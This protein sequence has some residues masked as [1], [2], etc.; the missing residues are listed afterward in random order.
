MR[1]RESTMAIL[2]T[3]KIQGKKVAAE[4]ANLIQ[5]ITVSRSSLRPPFITM[6][7]PNN[8]RDANKA[9]IA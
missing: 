5:N 9:A 4:F 2:I 3:V 8:Q 1:L 7:T 6:N